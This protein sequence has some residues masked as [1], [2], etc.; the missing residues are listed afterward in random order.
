MLSARQ[1]PHATLCL[2]LASSLVVLLLGMRL[3]KQEKEVLIE[4]DQTPVSRFT[5]K[6][7]REIES[8][9]TLYL[10]HLT[11]IR[12]RIGPETSEIAIASACRTIVG[13]EQAT[14]LEDDQRP[15]HIDLR[16]SDRS[17]P[18]PLPRRV[19]D[20]S[21]FNGVF[22]DVDRLAGFDPKP[23]YYWIG[24]ANSTLHFVTKSSY[25]TVLVLRI[26]PVPLRKS[27]ETWIT[28]WLNPTI[29]PLKESGL[30]TSFKSPSG[31]ELASTGEPH[32]ST[33]PSFLLPIPSRV[34]DWQLASWNLTETVT[35]YHQATLIGSAAI[36]I[37]LALAG[38]FGFSQHQR[39]VRLA[40]QRV[41]FVNRVS[42]ELRTPMTNILLNTDLLSD[43]LPEEGTTNMK[44]LNLVRDE[45]NRLSRLIENV[46]TF[47]MRERAKDDHGA[48]N[49]SL[50]LSR[51]D[52]SSSIKDALSKFESTLSR[53]GIALTC[54]Y[55]RS[56]IYVMADPDALSQIFGNLIS[57][58]EKYAI[59]GKRLEISTQESPKDGTVSVTF[60]DNGPGIPD[61]DEAKIFRPFERLYDSTNEGV[62][63]TGLGL[64]IALD[65]AK[66]M[67]GQLEL[68]SLP[69]SEFTGAHFTLTLPALA[70]NIVPIA[71]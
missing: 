49:Q 29:Q 56:P 2:I 17:E 20:D 36:S 60:S 67:G 38:I 50:R 63:G 30:I 22:I 40:E 34:G 37:I 55:P 65:L 41:S 9:D 1:L 52:L 3:A 43:S 12:N 11:A 71:S 16:E 25:N 61:E 44:R 51:C 8:L 33:A 13:I 31:I 23:K 70:E 46:L 58:V 19:G 5:S 10:D 6:L 59:Q 4:Q 14:L 64:A 24:D 69:Q 35:S 27:A 54:H 26:N 68:E 45:A 48:T 66:S 39:A 57:N 7:L 32:G 18:L 21:K 28:Q 62:S 42:H 53:N 47:S 15:K